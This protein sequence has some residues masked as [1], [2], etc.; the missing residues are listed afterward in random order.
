MF[1]HR[2]IR[3]IWHPQR[4]HFQL[5]A[6]FD[7]RCPTSVY[8][9][10]QELGL[11]QQ[12]TQARAACYGPNRMHVE[13][14]P[15]AQLFF[16]EALQPL[17]VFQI[18][19]CILWFTQN[20]V[21]FSFVI[22]LMTSISWAM[23]VY[24]TRR[25]QSDLR[26]MVGVSGHVSI[27]RDG[28]VQNLSSAELVPGDVVMLDPEGDCG[29]NVDYDAV[30]ISGGCVMNESALTGESVPVTKTSL[31]YTEGAPKEVQFLRKWAWLSLSSSS[32]FQIFDYRT[33]GKHVLYSGTKLLQIRSSVAHPAK[34]VVIRTGFHTAKGRL[35]R[36]ILFPKPIDYRFTKDLLIFLLTLGIIGLIG[37]IYSAI[38]QSKFHP[39]SYVMAERILDVITIVVPPLLPAAMSVGVVL[40]QR[41]L[42]R[43]KIFCI[44]PSTI[45]AC[46]SVDAVC[47]DKTGTLTEDGLDLAKVRTTT[48][49]RFDDEK[50]SLE[51]SSFSH[52]GQ[53]SERHAVRLMATCHTLVLLDPTE[54]S[55]GHEAR[56]GGDPIDTALFEKTGWRL[57]KPSGLT[58]VQHPSCVGV[59]E[60][61]AT[62]PSDDTDREKFL[63]LQ[64]FI[65]TSN[66]KRMSVIVRDQVSGAYSAYCKGAPETIKG[67]CL[68]ET[69]P[70]DFDSTLAEY[71]KEGSRVIAMAVKRLSGSKTSVGSSTDSPPDFDLKQWSRD[72]VES[73]M[74]FVGFCILENRLKAATTPVIYELNNANIRP[75]MITGDHIDTAIH[76]ARLCGIAPLDKRLYLVEFDQHGKHPVL[77][78]VAPPAHMEA[79][80]ATRSPM[81]HPDFDDSVVLSYQLAITGMVSSSS[82]GPP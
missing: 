28:I 45:N 58:I 10:R 62:T 74:A 51:I 32:L 53:G 65:F 21:L 38:V 35:V 72:R 16:R 30:L 41:R 26:R 49:G 4:S 8:Y 52:H 2:K 36:S 3:F 34:A 67:L 20:Y 60:G 19:S 29:R 5:L 6:D 46:G 37:M 78:L 59:A 70:S 23:N 40:A 17:A 80:K 14:T 63:I 9:Q 55:E 71:T 64:Q 18:F 39:S 13:L 12:M 57:K 47:F 25:S 24:S 11:T 22:I 81:D 50:A 82:H 66:L 75:V 42:R 56:I 31:F 27:L 73:D 1:D 15:I 68:P 33:H 48:R 44:S 79:P 54:P 43:K 77:K 76:V 61:P 7:Q 69:L